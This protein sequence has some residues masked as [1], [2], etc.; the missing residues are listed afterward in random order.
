M[1]LLIV[2]NLT[3]YVLKWY[4]KGKTR[5]QSGFTGARESKWQWHQPGH[6][7]MYT[8]PQTDS[9]TSIPPL[10]FLQAAMPRMHFLL[11]NQQHQTTEGNLNHITAYS[12]IVT[13]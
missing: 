12:V 3:Y 10:S 9:H 11:P 8:S 7:Q 13:G 1:F 6:M 4:Q 2:T 5:N